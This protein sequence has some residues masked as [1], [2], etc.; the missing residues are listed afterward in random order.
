ML[1]FPCLESISNYIG[2]WLEMQRVRLVV[3]QTQYKKQIE[4]MEEEE[5]QPYNI[6]HA[7]GFQ[8]SSSSD[9]DEEEEEED[10]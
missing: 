5:E 8:S 10:D 3:R 9:Y 6:T 7:I 1:I 4:Q 2:Q